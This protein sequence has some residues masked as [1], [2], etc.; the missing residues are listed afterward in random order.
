MKKIHIKIPKVKTRVTWGFNPVT[1]VSQDKKGYSR[2]SYKKV[3]QEKS[4]SD[5]AK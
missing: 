2:A 4:F 1:R 3:L 5:D